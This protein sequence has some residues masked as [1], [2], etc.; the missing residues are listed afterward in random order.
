M[1]MHVILHILTMV[2]H[3]QDVCSHVA[4]QWFHDGI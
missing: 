2:D 4:A 1:Y 3:K